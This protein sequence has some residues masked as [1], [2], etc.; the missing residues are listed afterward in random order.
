[1]RTHP[2]IGAEVLAGEGLEDL[3][4]WVVAHHERPDGKGYPERLTDAEIPL[5]AKIIAVADAYEAMTADRVYRPGIGTRAARVG[6]A[7]LRRDAVRLARDRGV[8]GGAGLARARARRGAGRPP[9][10]KPLKRSVSLVIEGP[11]GVLL[12]R[13]PDDDDSLPGL[14]GLPAASLREGESER[15]ALLRVGRAKLGVEVEPLRPIGEDE[16]ERTEHRIA[17][18]DWAARVVAGEPAVP[19]A[20]EGTQYVELRWGKPA[21][22]EPAARAGSVCARVLLRSLGSWP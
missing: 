8:H 14:W 3:R 15:E 11:A 18:R 19:Q 21:E 22:L 7:A 1:M 17:M 16:A 5:E 6:A 2:E 13:R 10:L 9:V 12:V 4:S 20:G